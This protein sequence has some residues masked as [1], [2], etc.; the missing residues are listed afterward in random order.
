MLVFPSL[1]EAPSPAPPDDD[2]DERGRNKHARRRRNGYE[3]KKCSE[4][5]PLADSGPFLDSGIPAAESMKLSR[6]GAHERQYAFR[7]GDGQAHQTRTAPCDP[8]DRC[9]DVVPLK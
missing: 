5:R 3:Q 1:P 4:H 6:I 7:L 8:G 2:G 9:T